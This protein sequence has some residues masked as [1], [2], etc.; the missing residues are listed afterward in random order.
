MTSVERLVPLQRER[1]VVDLVDD[2]TR[3]RG[4]LYRSTN[5]QIK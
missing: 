4:R 1:G 2:A 5:K 3:S